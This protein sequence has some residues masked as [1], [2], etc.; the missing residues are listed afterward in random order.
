MNRFSDIPLFPPQASTVAHQVDNLYFFLLAVSAFFALLIAVLVIGFAIR[1]RRR[2]EDDLPQ[3]IHGSL[4]L[5]I[6][7]TVVPFGLTLVMFF[8]GA[9][10]F[11]TIARPPDNALE[12]FV[13]GRQWMW[14]L[15]HMEGRREINELHVPL[16][17]P[18]KLTMTAEDVIHSF[19]VPAFRIK[20][21]VLPARYTTIWFE[22]TKR[23][24]YH[25]FCAEYCGTEHSRMT[26]RVVVMD[27]AD[28]QA[29]LTG[30]PAE[31]A[32]AAGTTMVSAGETLFDRF[33][34]RT[35][36]QNASGQLGPTLVGLFNSRVKL[37]RGGTV[38]ADEGYLRESIVNPQ[39]KIV[40]GYRPVMPTFQGQISEDELLQLIQYIKWLSGDSVPGDQVP[41][42]AAGRPGV[43]PTARAAR[44]SAPQTPAPTTQ[45]R[46]RQ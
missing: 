7:W 4:G 5:E 30:A 12:I 21:D 15:Q 26:G 35:C 36:H 18:I 2:S 17:R 38:R 6:F 29:W 14:K 25:L 11:L 42:A 10:V 32:A 46:R 27:P 41:A 34:C 33:G 28:Y 20:A 39:A 40:A 1:F 45:P 9:S 24:T 44:I 13:V 22:P 31:V 3:P 37:E 16:G 23:G 8:W 19:F 43:V